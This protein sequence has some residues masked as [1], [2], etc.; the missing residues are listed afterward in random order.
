MELILQGANN[1]IVLDSSVPAPQGSR[2]QLLV[3]DYLTYVAYYTIVAEDVYPFL[4]NS[5]L[6][7]AM[8]FDNAK[9]I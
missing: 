2:N 9:Y 3:G 4:S 8:T 6:V 5:L 1:P 7:Y